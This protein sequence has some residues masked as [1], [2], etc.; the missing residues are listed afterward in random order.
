M[1]LGALA[2]FA[3]PAQGQDPDIEK[4]E[5]KDYHREYMKGKDS[6]M[7][8]VGPD[9]TQLYNEFMGFREAEV[10]T[11]VAR[12]FESSVFAPYRMSSQMR[13][14]VRGNHVLID[15]TAR[16]DAGAE[17][18]TALEDLG[19][20]NV[21]RSGRLVSATVPI[22]R[23]P[24]VAKLSSLQ[25]ASPSVVYRKGLSGVESPS[26]TAKRDGAPE[27]RSQDA[28][29]MSGSVDSQG[30]AAMNTDEVRSSLGID[31]AGQTVGV[32]SDSYDNTLPAV[33]YSINASDDRNS[34]DLP[35]SNRI[36]VLDDS[37]PGRDEGRAMMQLVHDVAP[38]ADL[39]FHTAA[40]G[41][42]NFANG[43]EDLADAGA[44]VI[45][46]DIG[47]PNE[48]FFQDGRIAQAV[49]GV[50]ARDIPY[51][52]AAG[53]DNGRPNATYSSSWS[54]ATDAS[55]PD[56]YDFDPS[57]GTDT[58]QTFTIDPND[59]GLISIALQWDDPWAAVGPTGADT[60][61]NAYLIAGDD[62]SFRA[63]NRQGNQI[64]VLVQEGDT[65][66]TTLPRDNRNGNPY[67]ALLFGLNGSGSNDFP[68]VTQ[69]RTQPIPIELQ[70][71][72]DAGPDPGRI[73][74]I[75]VGGETPTEYQTPDSPQVYGHANSERGASVAAAYYDDTPE[76]G[77]SPAV[78]ES[79]SSRRTFPILFDDAGNRLGSPVDRQQPRVT[80]P[81]GTNTTFFVD[82]DPSSGAPPN[83]SRCGNPSPGG[84]NY[85]ESD[86]NPNFFGTSA[87][88][89]H[90]AGLAALQ[91]EAAP[92]LSV[93]EIYSNIEDGA[94]DMNASGVDPVTGHG[95]V[96]AENMI[97]RDLQIT[98]ND[99]RASFFPLV[100][101]VVTVTDSDGDVV[102]GLGEGN[103]AVE[104]DGRPETVLN[105]NELREV[106]G[107]VSSSLVLD[108]SGSMGGG[109][110]GDAKDAAKTFVDQFMAGD[111]AAV[112][113]FSSSVTLDQSF[114]S[115]AG[116]LKSAIDNLSSGGGT[117]LYDG[118]VRGVQ[119]IELESNSPA[120]LALT[121]GR[122]NSSSNSKQDAI[123]LANQV[124]VPVY[125]IGLG[126]NVN[127][128]DL[129]EVANQT[130]GQFFRAPN[131]S[132]L[133]AIY[134]EIS[135]QLSSRYEVT[136]ATSNVQLDGTQRTIELTAS[137][138]GGAVG[139]DSTTYTA[140]TIRIPFIPTFASAPQPGRTAQA[141]VEVGS[142]PRPADDLFRAT[143]TLSYDAENL[144][145]VNDEPGSF[146]GSGVEYR[147]SINDS[148]GTIDIGVRS[149]SGNSKSL[150]NALA[151]RTA[152]SKSKEQGTLV[153]L[154]FSVASDAPSDKEYDLSLSRVDVIDSDG[155]P[156]A[157]DT[158]RTP[159][160]PSDLQ[161]SDFDADQG[162]GTDTGEFVDIT[163]SSTSDQAAVDGCTFVFFDGANSESYFATD[164]SGILPPGSTYRIGNP[165]VSDVDQT[166]ADNTLQSGPDA[167]ALYKAP[168]A[169]FPTGTPAGDNLDKRQSAVVYTS[170][171]N[172]FGCYNA[173]VSGCQGKAA[174]GQSPLLRLDELMRAVENQT[175][176]EV[177]L[178]QNYPNP[179]DEKTTL[180]YGLPE[181]SDVEV[182]LY[183]V[184][185]RRVRTIQSGTQE[186]GW[187]R[188]TLTARDLSTGTY[189]V[190]LKSG[191]RV[192]TQSITLVR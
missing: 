58:L 120:V 97:A 107:N 150:K 169:D 116:A 14:P 183:D 164:L 168:V 74:Y 102:T 34:G 73:A 43:I 91:Q 178:K 145:V 111:Q 166:I 46:D 60:D 132:D 42:A 61:L 112:I 88:A 148:E 182:A 62:F 129:Q 144:D 135:Q 115:D 154:E 149:G 146:F 163:N 78:V 108:R 16:P 37:E 18:Q 141:S 8:S 121:D 98:F 30:D 139:I 175:P 157:V 138:G 71:V 70:I 77:T 32:L 12:A 104:E 11:K 75:T 125:T 110:L 68:R 36:N 187:Y 128:G 171:D 19:A 127:A 151:K 137:T 52:S 161:I 143:F 6:S 130:G 156:I 106:G 189:F 50:V 25:S 66:T 69:G 165:G 93:S 186:A 95:F 57:T 190:R 65:L 45:V 85:C 10:D 79:F 84:A 39:A 81:D 15:A 2:L 40:G 152:N 83:D 5:M 9:L 29:P 136:Y 53:N 119:E 94:E 147:S 100:T 184:L 105:V 92:G 23:L 72:R 176:D 49:D 21:A 185:G 109:E 173:S 114:T 172:I 27:V 47:Y 13:S 86:G 87:A 162:S 22:E 142:A 80:G 170:D 159:R 140:P 124:G 180:R 51:F 7:A 101:S 177:T 54:G 123:D 99:V 55:R 90:V 153:N 48:P 44:D 20:K 155:N 38:A 82:E 192:E 4:Q 26:G 118:I 188:A 167:L 1:L 17:L 76:F 174:S 63:R 131:S 59:G 103:F 31:G 134:E 64:I 191:E 56:V 181:Q 133:E 3:M 89:P 179:F 122:E 113:S 24:D 160:C 126:G 117:A 41:K 35:S 158:A 67:Q 33:N 96:N 28:A